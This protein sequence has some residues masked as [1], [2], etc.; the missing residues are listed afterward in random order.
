MS[1]T[2]VFFLQSV[3]DELRSKQYLLDDISAMSYKLEEETSNEA[4]KR[5]LREQIESL[6]NHWQNVQRQSDNWHDRIDTMWD[7]WGQYEQLKNELEAWLTTAEEKLDKAE[8]KNGSTVAELESLLEEHKVNCTRVKMLN[9]F[10]GCQQ[11]V[12]ACQYHSPLYGRVRTCVV[13][14][15]C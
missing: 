3:E 6:K 10:Q 2:N 9:L 14:R 8:K 13:P 12:L 7:I 15:H 5:I 11:L 1:T 4:H